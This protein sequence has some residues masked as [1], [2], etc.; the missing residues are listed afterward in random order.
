MQPHN[1]AAAQPIDDFTVRIIR[2]KARQ[3]VGR[4]G[5]TR[6]DVDDI[7]QELVMKV[8]K[9]R[10]AFDPAQACWHAFVA[11]IVERHTATLLRDKRMEKRDFTRATSLDVLV[12]D[13]IE[14]LTQMASTIGQREL[15]ARLGLK[16]R[17]EQEIAELIQDMKAVL[18]SLPPAW[19]QVCERLQTESV[20]QVSR[21]LGIAR[22]TLS[23]LLR[24]LRR[25]FERSQIR[26][27]VQPG[28]SD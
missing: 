19:R 25:R 6:S 5:F 20:S 21:D 27:Y 12:V 4:A 15:D 23:Y 11:T 3:L 28:S 24:R 13:P 17:P 14:G 1:D 2:R 18:D 22:T 8:L 10:A 9:N 7:E 26:E 16:T